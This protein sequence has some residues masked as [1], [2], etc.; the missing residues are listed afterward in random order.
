LDSDYQTLLTD[1]KS[2][3]TVLD[4]HNVLVEQYNAGIKGEKPLS[5]DLLKSVNRYQAA[6]ENRFPDEKEIAK[7]IG[8]LSTKITST[9]D[10]DAVSTD[11]DTVLQSGDKFL[12]DFREKLNTRIAE[13]QEKVN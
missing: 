9:T 8:D 6:F 12:A 2:Y 7:A 13:F 1:V 5:G 10:F 4:T 3:V 11:I